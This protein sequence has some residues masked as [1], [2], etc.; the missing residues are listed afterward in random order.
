[1]GAVPPLRVICVDDN[2]DAADTMAAVLELYGYEVRACYD[3]PSALLAVDEFQPDA[4]LLDLKMPGMDGFE[5]AA[6]IRSRAG[7]RPLLLVATT[8]QGTLED[9]TRTAFV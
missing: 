8:A 4:F 5:L 3:G 7:P 9:K 1:M 2:R 6:Q